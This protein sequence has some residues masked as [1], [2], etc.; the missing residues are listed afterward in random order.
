MLPAITVQS[1][2]HCSTFVAPPRKRSQIT[3]SHIHRQKSSRSADCASVFRRYRQLSPVLARFRA[4]AP[5]AVSHGPCGNRPSD[6]P[7]G[8]CRPW[9]GEDTFYTGPPLIQPDPAGGDPAHTSTSN[10]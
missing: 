7:G 10:H 2:Q 1:R 6:L 4:F 9:G 5:C 3:G 8:C